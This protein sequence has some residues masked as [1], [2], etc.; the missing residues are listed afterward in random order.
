MSAHML[1]AKDVLHSSTEPEK[2]QHITTLKSIQHT[3]A[4]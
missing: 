4:L 3:I 1:L 2:G